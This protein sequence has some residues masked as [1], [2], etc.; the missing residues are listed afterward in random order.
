M[1]L[2]FSYTYR[3]TWLQQNGAFADAK[4]A[5]VTQHEGGGA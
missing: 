3:A 4:E 2:V 1:N 5:D